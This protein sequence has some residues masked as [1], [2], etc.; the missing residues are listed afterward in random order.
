MACLC[1]S[2]CAYWYSPLG[3]SPVWG[4]VFMLLGGSL[5]GLYV[6]MERNPYPCPFARNRGEGAFQSSDAVR[7]SLSPAAGRDSGWGQSSTLPLLL[8]VILLGF[9]L[10]LINLENS[11]HIFVDEM[12]FADGV[13]GLWDVPQRNLLLPM[14]G[15]AG[16]TWLY[17]Y[18]QTHTVTIFGATLTGLRIVSVVF[19]TLTLPAVYLLARAWFDR[20]TALLA[21]LALA[22]LARGMFNP[23]VLLPPP[24]P[25]PSIGEGENSKSQGSLKP[26][27]PKRRNT[28]EREFRGEVHCALAGVALGFTQYFYEGGK[29]IFPAAAGVWILS[30]V[31]GWSNHRRD[32]LTGRP[33][34]TRRLRPSGIF[35]LAFA[36][37]IAPLV[38][39]LASHGLPYF[40]RTVSETADWR[41]WLVEPGGLH[42]YVREHLSPAFYHLIQH[43]DGAQYYGGGTGLILPV[44]VPFFLLG[45][46]DCLWRGRWALPG[47]VFL[48]VFGNSLLLH[49]D[50]SARFVV[51]L[52]ALALIIAGGMQAAGAV[53]VNPLPASSAGGGGE[54]R[55]A[56]DHNSI[57]PGSQIHHAP[58]DSVP[59]VSEAASVGRVRVGLHWYVV[60][61]A[62]FVSTQPLYYFGP[63]LDQFNRQVRPFRDHQ[64]VIWRARDLPPGTNALVFTDELVFLGHLHS[65]ERFWRVDLNVEFLHPLHLL[66]RSPS[67]LPT[68]ADLA[69]FIQ[70]ENRE[71]L[72]F[73]SQ[74]FDLP[75]PAYSPYN[76]PR[77]KQYVLYWI[78]RER[79]NVSPT[80]G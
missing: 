74:T 15:I 7:R 73:L 41:A 18:L 26:P 38:L 32:D 4:D 25:S 68:G 9:G 46:F 58:G 21:A 67:R 3:G 36:L 66:L 39:T 49:P 71:I 61:L 59:S 80:T 47:I 10:R 35:V 65:L 76:V 42:E 2:L 54:K 5:W 22:L 52:P 14:S 33:D 23:R 17:A 55:A 45:L 12:H 13:T 24:P 20:R 44:F 19:G 6:W 16:F 27:L 50:W 51:A 30:R 70:P 57:Q 29:L 1:L 56:R 69:I 11:V 64:D 31:I 60:L 48:T 28:M 34:N 37:T 8:P 79:T 43:P 62:L 53:L 78:K 40:P 77:E 72:R 75:P 63:H